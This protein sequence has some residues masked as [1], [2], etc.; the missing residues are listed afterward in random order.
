MDYSDKGSAGVFDLL[1]YGSSCA[2][3]RVS[4]VVIIPHIG[5]RQDA[6]K[7]VVSHACFIDTFAL[8]LL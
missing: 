2:F 4:N 6:A 8:K 1:R 3:A 5:W 7:I